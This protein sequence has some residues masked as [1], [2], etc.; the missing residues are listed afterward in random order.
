MPSGDQA[1]L[2]T[3]WLATTTCRS[4][5]SERIE[6]SPPDDENVTSAGVHT[7]NLLNPYRRIGTLILE[8]HGTNGNG[9]KV[10]ESYEPTAARS[11][12]SV[13][14]LQERRQTPDRA[15]LFEVTPRGDPQ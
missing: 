3:S 9:L 13:G 12:I 11:Y 4:L 7:F 10:Q 8:T 15:R 6:Y 14:A 1:G 2:A 5:P